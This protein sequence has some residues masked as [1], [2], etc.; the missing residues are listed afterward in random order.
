MPGLPPPLDYYPNPAADF[1]PR[2]EPPAPPPGRRLRWFLA[3]FLLA[4]ATS[5]LYVWQRPAVYQATASVLTVAPD[6]MDPGGVAADESTDSPA[7]PGPVP[8]EG[9]IQHVMVQRQTLLGTPLLEETRRLLA[10]GESFP[11]PVPDLVA[12]HDVLSVATVPGTNLV[13]L[14]ARGPDPAILAPLVNA[15]TDAYEALRL[16]AARNTQVATTTALDDETTQLAR[17]VEAKRTELEEFRRIHDIVST[18]DTDN[19]ALARLKG[20]NDALNK[21]TEEEAKAQG[22]LDAVRAAIA[23]GRPVLAPREAQ[24]LAEL[25]KTAHDLRQQAK[26]IAKRFTSQYSLLQ[27]QV[28]DVPAQLQQIEAAIAAKQQEATASALSEAEQALAAARQSVTSLQRQMTALKKEAATFTARFARHDALAKD[29]A[30]LEALYRE[31][32]G[33]QVR[34][35]VKPVAIE[36]RL[37]IID[38]AY[39]PNRP[40]WPDYWRDSGIALGGS[41][42]LALLVLL[43]HDFVTRRERAAALRMPDIRVFS[44]SEQLMLRRQEESALALQRLPGSP[45]LPGHA[46][47][48]LAA[49]EPRELTEPELR[50]LLE[51]ADEPARQAIALLLS[52]LT[53]EEAAALGPDA[54]DLAAG[55]LHSGGDRPRDLPLAP[56]LRAWLAGTAARPAWSDEPQPEAADLAAHVAYAA[57]DAGLADPAMVDAAALRHTYIIHLVRQGLRLADL[58]RVVGK[59]PPRVLAGY[60]RFSPAGPGL[61]AESVPLVHPVLAHIGS[62]TT[63]P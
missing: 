33:R 42:G 45:A 60:A 34:V 36:P 22:R 43:I 10:Q 47:P 29:L 56:R 8:V 17:R 11:G 55:R 27:P 49:P 40:I 26:D 4:L 41:L 14:R 63:P 54:I 21:A 20:L 28:K 37:Q 2:V 12:L 58:E 13:E 7:T 44:V 50:L 38:R 16:R 18:R 6:S 57:A 24:G 32:Q 46:M 31:A 52:G 1:P 51:A 59:L 35:E 61:R 39:T 19:Q 9:G 3:V 53:L 23:R 30:Q 15:W 48:S 25:E 5:L 62:D